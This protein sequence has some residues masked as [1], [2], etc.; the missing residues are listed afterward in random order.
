M[1]DAVALSHFFLWA[2]LTMAL[3]WG[4]AC[5]VGESQKSRVAQRQYRVTAY[6]ERR[7]TRNRSR[8]EPADCGIAGRRGGA[9]VYL[10]IGSAQYLRQLELYR[11]GHGANQVCGRAG[12]P[13][14]GRCGRR[15]TCHVRDVGGAD[16]GECGYN[17]VGGPCLGRG[18]LSRS[19]PRYHGILGTGWW[20]GCRGRGLR[21]RLCRI[22]GRC[23]W[24]G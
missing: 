6:R 15:A 8:R 24:V 18:G 3:N 19:Q 11:R 23:L 4:A 10:G 9:P 14:A 16:G 1:G 7:R 2:P 17:C 21:V 20:F 22:S 12:S 13:S 5:D